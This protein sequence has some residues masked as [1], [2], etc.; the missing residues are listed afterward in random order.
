[1]SGK[2]YGTSKPKMIVGKSSN[3]GVQKISH[4]KYHQKV[5]LSTIADK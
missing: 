5:H 1:M 4:D 2:K 3:T